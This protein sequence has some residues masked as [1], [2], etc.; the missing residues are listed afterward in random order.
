MGSVGKTITLAVGIGLIGA[1]GCES[2][3]FFAGV[4]GGSGAGGG[5]TSGAL[6]VG[7]ACAAS[8][9]CRNGLVCDT[10]KR[11]ASRGT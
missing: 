1:A 11:R 2:G 5:S 8:S 9:E 7:Q 4:G 3:G 10:T 6:G